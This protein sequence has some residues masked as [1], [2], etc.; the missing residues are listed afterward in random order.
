MNAP[1]RKTVAAQKAATAEKHPQMTLVPDEAAE[2]HP[3][4]GQ[5]TCAATRWLNGRHVQC[6]LKVGHGGHHSEGG[7]SWRPRSGDPA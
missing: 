5:T 2:A 7:R 3:K 1:A 6:E 4:G